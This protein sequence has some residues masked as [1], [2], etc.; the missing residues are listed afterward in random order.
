MG[1]SYWPFIAGNNT[2]TILMQAGPITT[3]NMLG[4]IKKMRGKQQL[5]RQFCGHLFGFQSTSRTHCIRMDPERLT[6]AGPK[7]IRLHKQCDQISHLFQ[8]RRC[9]RFLSASCRD[10]PVRNSI[11]R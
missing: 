4:K 5:Y 6:N 9:A 8:I 1:L 2:R 10:T 7:P 11:A 3:I